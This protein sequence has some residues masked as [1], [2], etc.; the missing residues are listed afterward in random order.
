LPVFS[1]YPERST[2]KFTI[3]FYKSDNLAAAYGI[4]VSAAMLITCLSFVATREI[5]HWPVAAA[6]SFWSTPD[7]SWRMR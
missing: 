2:I 4:A 3:L 6:Y 5:W 7:S 1:E